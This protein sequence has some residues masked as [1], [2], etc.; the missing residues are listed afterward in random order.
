[1]ASV[2]TDTMSSHAAAEPLA[3]IA[4]STAEQIRVDPRPFPVAITFPAST[5]YSTPV[6]I[7][8]NTMIHSPGGYE[9]T[10]FLRTGVPLSIL[11]WILSAILIPK[12]WSFLGDVA[13]PWRRRSSTESSAARSAASRN[14]FGIGMRI[15]D[16]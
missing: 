2:T 7:Q 12:F 4:I 14:Q 1:M 16:S 3:P 10:D 13:G 6:A 15:A 11:F 8:T 5:G 9:Y